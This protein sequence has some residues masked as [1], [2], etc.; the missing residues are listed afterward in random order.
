MRPDCNPYRDIYG[1]LAVRSHPLRN[2]ILFA[3]ASHLVNLGRLPK[4][5]LQPYRK[6]MRVA[7]R[8]GIAIETD[9]EGLAA[10]ALLSVVFDVQEQHTKPWN[11]Y[12]MANGNRLLI[13]AWTLGVRDF[14]GA[15]VYLETPW[16][17]RMEPMDGF[18][19]A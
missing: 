3:S 8:E 14:L 6:A 10:T 1:D 16:T 9:L 15:V 19:N 11:I 13:L 17:N 5:A 4:F 2:T 7:F 18:F 12:L